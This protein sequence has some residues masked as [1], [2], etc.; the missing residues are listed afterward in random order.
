HDQGALTRVV[1]ALVKAG[2]VD[3]RRS[4]QDRRRVEVQ[5][6][7]AGCDYVDAQMPFVI[8]GTNRLLEAF[9]NAEVDQLRDLLVR[10][11]A[12]LENF[13]LDPPPAT[14]SAEPTP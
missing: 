4:Q 6:T 11:I 8:A 1:D 12:R 3:R 14:D 10:L 13:D 9:T 7:A 2:F 5:L